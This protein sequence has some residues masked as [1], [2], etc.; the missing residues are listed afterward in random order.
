MN[1]SGFL[2]RFWR[3]GI[4]VVV[5]LSFAGGVSAQDSTGREIAKPVAKKPA[6]KPEKKPAK[7]P[8]KKTSE[9]RP[10]KKKVAPATKLTISAPPGTL[11][12]ID[13]SVKGF[14]GVDGNLTVLGVTAGERKLTATAEGYE[15][16]NGSFSMGTA[17]M[18]FEVPMRRKPDPGKIAVT[19]N[20]PGAVV[21]VD[22][23]ETIRPAPG[24]P[25]L[26]TG[27]ATGTHQVRATKTGFREWRGAVSVEP[28]KTASVKIELKLLIDPVMMLIEE[29]VFEQGNNNGDRDQRPKHQVFVAAF[30]ISRGEITNR[31][32]KKF[33]DAAGHPPP[34]GTGYGWHANVY[35]AGH[36]DFPVVFVS[37]DDAV[38]FCRWLSAETGN[39]YRLPTEAEWEK[40]VSTENTSDR[41]SS[42]GSVWE[43]CSDWYDADYYKLRD[44]INPQGPLT[45]KKAKMMGFEGATKVLRGGGFG[46]GQVLFRARERNHYFPNKSRFDIG[47]RVVREITK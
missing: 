11:V 4:A 3:C 1:R 22:D 18:R 23:H 27:L 43:W 20:E 5:L 2:G 40:A 30:E 37:W 13:G 42:I 6:E 15:L 33:V 7:Q 26:L 8:A 47:F 19:I 10:T 12:E 34:Q 39:K 45:G 29:G 46:R 9:A 14:T 31:L 16:W 41:F 38:A 28:G 17:S 25:Y 35:P 32:Y 24:Q 36:D 44:R 21:V